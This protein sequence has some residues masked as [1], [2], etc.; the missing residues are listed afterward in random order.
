M[1]TASRS[2][3]RVKVIGEYSAMLR[4]VSPVHLEYLANNRT[5][6]AVVSL[7]VPDTDFAREWAARNDAPND[8]VALADNPAF[9]KAVSAAVDRVNASLAPR[10]L[11]RVASR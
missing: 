7:V 10:D 5:F 8:L 3:T 6:N 4:S 9:N 1:R 11:T 2:P